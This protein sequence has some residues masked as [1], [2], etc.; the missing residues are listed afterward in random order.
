M[1]AH[2]PSTPRDQADEDFVTVLAEQRARVQEFA[3]RSQQRM[4]DLEADLVARVERMANSLAELQQDAVARESTAN[5]KQAE[6]ETVQAAISAKLSEIDARE[7]ALAAQLAQATEDRRRIA[8]RARRIA[9]RIRAERQAFREERLREQAAHD[10]SAAA[11]LNTLREQLA[12]LRSE[13]DHGQESAQALGVQLEQAR[14]EAEALRPLR[15]EAA[16]LQQ[17][18]A[19]AQGERQKVEAALQ[20]ATADEAARHEEHQAAL[21]GRDRQLAEQTA[22]REQL[23]AA[24][25][26][27][28]VELAQAGGERDALRTERERLVG[29]AA[30]LQKDV[31]QA[32]AAL[33]DSSVQAQALAELQAKLQQSETERRKLDEQIAAAAQRAEQAE[34]RLRESEEQQASQRQTGQ[35]ELSRLNE[36]LAKYQAAEQKAAQEHA[37]LHGRCQELDQALSKVKEE[38]DRETQQAASRVQSLE[39][40]LAGARRE[41]GAEAAA[42]QELLSRLSAAEAETAQSRDEI[43]R[44]KNDLAVATDAEAARIELQAAQAETAKRL[45]ELETERLGLISKCEALTEQLASAPSASG[46]DAELEQKVESLEKRYALAMEDLREEKGRAA[47]LELKLAEARRSGGGGAAPAGGGLDWEAQKRRM[48]AMLEEYDDGTEDEANERLTIQGTLEITDSVVAA[49][50]AEIAELHK[51]LSEQSSNIG[52]VA[53][54]AAAIA[55][56]VESDEVIQHE[57]ERARQLQTEWEGKMRTAEVEISVERAKLARERAELEEKLRTLEERSASFGAHAPANP[58]AAEHKEPKRGRWLERLGLK[59]SS[60]G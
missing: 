18:L 47:E 38:F 16:R 60:S 56:L 11:E 43:A 14:S 8:T 15:D 45:K 41:G 12:A 4:R 37:K 53:V 51:L 55:Q 44:L 5:G 46:G 57:R 27:V 28:Q 1:D 33:A 36:Q 48:L 23:A 59:D 52:N 3:S 50:D 58:G 24:L 32:R 54:G 35:S 49:K 17:E 25:Q 30:A 10:Q 26:A 13:F 2:L 7:S 42:Q 19:D 31:E 39:Q 34:R 6:A 40:D 20:Q 9:G 22:E 21:T 29:E